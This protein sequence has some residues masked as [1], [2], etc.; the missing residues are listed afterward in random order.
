VTT[1]GKEGAVRASR[2]V[3]HDLSAAS[4]VELSLEKGGET[5]C[6]KW[7]RDVE[8]GLLRDLGGDH[9]EETHEYYGYRDGSDADEDR[10]SVKLELT[11]EQQAQ[12]F[13]NL[14][15]NEEIAA[16]ASRSGT[17]FSESDYAVRGVERMNLRMP[18]D[19]FERLDALVDESGA[20]S[21]SEQIQQLINDAHGKLGK[22]R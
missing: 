20:R 12:R 6:G 1:A 18:L 9:N 15:H 17:K 3:I 22:A 19:V 21:R 11:T 16:R 5:V 2:P 8:Q 7:S 4:L 13:R 10:W 14:D